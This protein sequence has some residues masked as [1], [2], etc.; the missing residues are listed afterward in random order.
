M[1]GFILT[2]SKALKVEPLSSVFALDGTLISVS[3]APTARHNA[4]RKV[5]DPNPI[6]VIQDFFSVLTGCYP[7]RSWNCCGPNGKAGT[8][9]PSFNH[10]TDAFL[11][12]ARSNYLSNTAGAALSEPG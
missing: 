9:Q 2:H 10:F 3:A 11:K 4:G 5:L 8:T 6:R 12:G 1:Y 7:E